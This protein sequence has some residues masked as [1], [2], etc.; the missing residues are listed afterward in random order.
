MAERDGDTAGSPASCPQRCPTPT[1]SP[2]AAVPAGAAAAA[3]NLPLL[4]AWYPWGHQLW[5]EELTAVNPPD[6]PHASTRPERSRFLHRGQ[7]RSG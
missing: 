4:G 7:P 5:E 1:R 3:A 6:P 2:G